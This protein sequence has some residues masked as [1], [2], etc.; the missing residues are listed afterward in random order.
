MKNLLTGWLAVLTLALFGL[1]SP[2]QAQ[3]LATGRDYNVI[4]P[5]MVTDEPAK[6]EVLEFF[7]YGCPH[8]N[9]LNPL[10]VKWAAKQPADVAFRRVPVGFGNPYYQLMA[11]LYYSLEALG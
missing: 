1:A 3:Q 5:A 4:E 10:L 11:R 8:C 6:I 9:D 7:S 2:A